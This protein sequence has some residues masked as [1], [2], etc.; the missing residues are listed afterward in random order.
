MA[1]AFRILTWIVAAGT[2][3]AIVNG[4]RFGI[5]LGIACLA[6]SLASLSYLKGRDRSS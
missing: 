4:D 1:R 6:V 2:V 3:L 5:V